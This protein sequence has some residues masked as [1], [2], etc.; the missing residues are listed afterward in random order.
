MRTY[1]I[2]AQVDDIIQLN[3]LDL[4]YNR[5]YCIPWAMFYSY[6]I[7][8]LKIKSAL[9]SIASE[10]PVLCGRLISNPITGIH[11]EV[12]KGTGFCFTYVNSDWTLIEAL[13][14]SKLQGEVATFPSYPHLPNCLENLNLFELIDRDTPVFK[15]KLVHYK[16]GTC[17]LGATI[18]HSIADAQRLANLFVEISRAYCGETLCQ[19]DY[20]RSRL[21]PDQLLQKIDLGSLPQT[22]LRECRHHNEGPKL[23]VYHG[24][25]YLIETIYFPRTDIEAIKQKVMDNI[26]GDVDYVSQVDV[27]SAVSWMLMCELKAIR[28]GFHKEI[29]TAA[30]LNIFEAPHVFFMELLSNNSTLIPAN[31]FGNGFVWNG[32]QFPKTDSEQNQEDDLFN[33]LVKASVS[34]RKQ[35]LENRFPEKHAQ[36]ILHVYKLL[37]EPSENPSF[38]SIL[39]SFCKMPINEIDFGKGPPTYPLAL[40]AYPFHFPATTLS[41]GGAKDG[42][43]M[44]TVIL[45]DERQTAMNSVVLQEF[46]PGACF[47]SV[48]SSAELMKFF[49]FL[50]DQ[51]EH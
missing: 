38:T 39:S 46:F 14:E 6:D 8:A 50:S 23:T 44:N 45:E 30:D 18:H 48:M 31:Y 19:V 17:S 5:F 3:P 25:K 22:F 26:Q 9:H 21:W 37:N 33:T 40:S 35:I 42:I 32:A 28:S 47:L 43:I 7:S 15:V 16:D 29:K 4:Y 13:S 49:S 24:N 10:Y 11:V 2:C 27:I 41:S 1:S 20:D 12:K 51:N 34:I 36:K